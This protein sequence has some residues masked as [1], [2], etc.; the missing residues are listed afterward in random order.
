MNCSKKLEWNVK[1]GQRSEEHTFELSHRS[2][3]GMPFSAGKKKKKSKDKAQEATS[4]M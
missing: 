2:L 4:E 1:K 3:P